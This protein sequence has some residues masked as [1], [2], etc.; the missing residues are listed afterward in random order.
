MPI[1]SE[2]DDT[3]TPQSQ[4][5]G[6]H[7]SVEG[8]QFEED[9]SEARIVIRQEISDKVSHL[10]E[11]DFDMESGR[12]FLRNLNRIGS[13]GQLDSFLRTGKVPKRH[14]RN[15]K[16]TPITRYLH[17]Q[18]AAANLV[19][20]VAK[21]GTLGKKPTLTMT[22]AL[23]RVAVGRPAANEP[24]RTSKV[25]HSLNKNIEKGSQNARKH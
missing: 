9:D 5:Q 23:K 8:G 1:F 4:P 24:P 13:Y 16:I 18:R 19:K 3:Y 12:Q 22:K 2:I 11:G 6:S 10:L 15:A 17:R 21:K 14:N 7:R 25:I 20:K